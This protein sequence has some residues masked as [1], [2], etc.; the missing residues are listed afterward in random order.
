[1]NPHRIRPLAVC[2]VRNGD[3]ILVEHGFD[4]V[5]GQHFL[6][7]LGGGIEFGERVIDAVR[8]EFQEELNANL[9]ELHLRGVLENLFKYEGASGHEIVFVFEG[10]FRDACLNEVTEFTVREPPSAGRATWVT[11]DEVSAGS[12]PLYPDGLIALLTDSRQGS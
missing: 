1:M 4:T 10:V 12:R 11:L 8:R 9:G 3:R 5:K 6:R 7:P 2:V